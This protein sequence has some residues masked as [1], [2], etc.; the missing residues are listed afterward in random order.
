MKLLL[1]L[2]VYTTMAGATGTDPLPPDDAFFVQK[3]KGHQLKIMTYNAYNL[4]DTVH[5]EG[6]FDYTF[7]PK[8][9]PGKAEE[10]ATMEDGPYKDQCANIDWTPE[11]LEKKIGQIVH[12]LQSHG[13]MPDVVALEEVENENVVGMLA[14]AAGYNKFLVTDYGNHRGVDVGIMYNDKKITLLEQFYVKTPGRDPYRLKFRHNGTKKVFYVYINHWLAQSAPVKYRIETSKLLRADIDQLMQKEPDARIIAMGDFNTEDAEEQQVFN[15]ILFDNG[16][17]HR[18]YD[19]YAL[20]RQEFPQYE[21][22]FP[23]GSYYW[24]G[25]AHTWRKFDRFL[26]SGPMAGPSKPRVDV[27]SFRVIYSSFL[28][29]PFTYKVDETNPESDEITVHLPIKFN[30]LD[31]PKWQLGYSDHLPISVLIDF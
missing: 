11:K 4:F 3:T 5:D 19:M 14:Q 23:T 25:K 18:L 2:L 26:I 8:D 13:S 15:E 30:F 16:W 22:K 9:F 10:C 6:A 28:T 7:L 21:K 31:N 29:A 12:V 27:E 24:G 20:S 1:A 17:N